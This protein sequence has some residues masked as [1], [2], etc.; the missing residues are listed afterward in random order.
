MLGS[1]EIYAI[2]NTAS[3]L[4]IMVFLTYIKQCSYFRFIIDLTLHDCGLAVLF[5]S[6]K[7]ICPPVFELNAV[8]LT[9]HLLIAL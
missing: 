7:A 6:I 2:H 8:A 1:V 4:S 5:L 3:I 9:V